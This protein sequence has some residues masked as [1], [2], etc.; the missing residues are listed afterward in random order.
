MLVV[1]RP[2]AT[3]AQID[4]VVGVIRERGLTPHPLPGATRTAIGMTGNTVA[5]DQALFEVL[6][7][8]DEA[9]RVTKPYKLASREMKRD[10][11]V[12]RTRFGA[13]GPGTFAVVAGPCSVENERM[14]VETAEFLV[15][16]AGTAGL[17][18]TYGD[19]IGDLLLSSTGGAVGAL[20]AVLLVGRR[21]PAPAA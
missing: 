7:G 8:V 20:A 1:M 10:D 2:D 14:I 21:R 9:I 3:P 16:K 4:A 13:V 5:V 12:V 17:Q 11:T 18:L 6:P 15:Q 19:T